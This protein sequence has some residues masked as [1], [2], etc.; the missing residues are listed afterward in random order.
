M[1]LHNL[2][3]T[4]H[5]KK[6]RRVARGGKRDGY[7]GRGI[8]GQRSR[9]GA[10][11][12]PA[13]RDLIKKI[14]KQRG[15]GKNIFKSFQVKAAIAKLTDLDSKFTDGDVISAPELI[16]VGLV[17]RFYGKMPRI[18]IMGDGFITKKVTVQGLEV[19]KSAKAKIESMGGV[20]S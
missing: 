5:R 8:K 17:E 11:I 1:Q 9:A 12:R 18:K 13:I 2:Q 20:V 4:H 19:S 14:P 15:R 3:P 10:K 6:A 16:K 7:S